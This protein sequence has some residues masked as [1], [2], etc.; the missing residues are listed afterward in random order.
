MKLIITL[1]FF[2]ITFSLKAQV[3][4]GTV[5]PQ[6]ALDV[7]SN[8]TGMLVPRVA[9]TATNASAPVVNP[10]GGAL[11]A[12][13]LIWNTATAG[14]SPTNVTP[15]Y[16]YWDGAAWTRLFA[17]NTNAWNLTGNALTTAANY[18]GTTDANPLKLSTAATERMRV[19]ANG[20]VVVNNVAAPA[21]NDRFS[22][23]N[24]TA[25]DNAIT[26]YSTSTG[27]GVHGRNTASGYGVY[28][29]NN[30]TGI[31][32]LGNNTSTGAGV[33]GIT[34]G[35]VSA[36][37]FGQANVA[38]GAGAY[39]TSNG[40][41]GLGVFG[42]STGAAGAGVYGQ[43]SGSLG[44][45]VFGYGGT[46]SDGVYGQASQAAYYGVWGVNNTGTGLAVIGT[47][48]GASASAVYGEVTGN[49]ATALDAYASGSSAYGV[50]SQT[51]GTNAVSSYATSSGAGGIGALGVTTGSNGIGTYGTANSATAFGVRASNTALNGVGLIANGNNTTATYM[52]GSGGTLRGGS[53]GV[54]G[55]GFTTA[56]GIGVAGAGNGITVFVGPTGGAGGSF[57]GNQW[58]AY[59]TSNIGGAANNGIDRA[60]FSGGYT[61]DNSNVQNIYVGAR[62]GGVHYKILGTGGGSVSTTMATSQGERVLFA[63]ESPENWFFD[64]GEVQL[65]NGKA[66]VK[67]DPIFVECI[68][69]AK[70]FKVFVQGG[71]DTMGYI[72][73][74]RNQQDKSFVLEDM[75]GA[76]NGTVQFSIHAIWKGKEGIRF[77]EFKNENKIRTVEDKMMSV[78]ETL[79]KT[80][81]KPEK[82]RR[83]ESEKKLDNKEKVAPEI[84][85]KR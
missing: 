71:E 52:A 79:Y 38:N 75:G 12:G 3:G 70:P 15:G 32:V 61:S 2:C 41:G 53:Y 4:V 39:G 34:N 1:V 23:Y 46:T 43:A 77:P 31:A 58:G 28:G 81:A 6:G 56:T 82:S 26:G 24:T 50:Y 29:F 44:T 20:Q 83:Q 11:V 72:R 9:L 40:G 64:M 35:A 22:V 48:T 25:T 47:S 80:Q 30:S 13:T 74:S 63:P 62:I 66:E 67:L 27:V 68:S 69:D 19:L 8:T 16:Y 33:L 57:N 10:Q 14:T 36:G 5:A 21:A 85:D 54:V 37:T 59:A 51:L 65:V 45:G 73:V 18:V 42:N 84:A 55:S 76:S 17:G 78:D 7:T 49:T 60:A